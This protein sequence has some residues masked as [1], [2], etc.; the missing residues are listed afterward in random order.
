[1][2][3]AAAPRDPARRGTATSSDDAQRVR[4]TLSASTRSG[5]SP[6][7]SSRDGTCCRTRA[8]TSMTAR[9][10][11]HRTEVRHVNHELLAIRRETLAQIADASI[12]LVRFAVDEVGNDA[13]VARHAEFAVGVGLEALGHR[14]HAVGLLDA[15][16]DDFRVRAIAAEQRDVGAVQRRDHGGRHAA[17]CAT[18]ESAARDTPRSR[19]ESRSARGRCRAARRAPPATIL[20][21]SDSRYCGSRKQRIA[22]RLD[23]MERQARL[24]VAKPNGVSRAEDVHAMAAHGQRLA[25]LGRDDAAAADRGVADDA[26]VH[27]S[28]LHQG[29]SARPARGRR[30]LRPD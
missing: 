28:A 14:R 30:S 15:E 27:G 2:P 19:A 12:A 6:T 29:R 10:A 23:A 25:E 1:M 11:L 17:L 7:I 20:L 13:D 18:R 21:A 26:D 5:P 22:R 8:K 3:T 9:H 24:I 16:R 4:Q